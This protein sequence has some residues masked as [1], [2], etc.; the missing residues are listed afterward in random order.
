[1]EGCGWYFLL[2]GVELV[3]SV[4]LVEHLHCV[5]FYV[6]LGHG[7][8]QISAL[9]EILVFVLNYELI[10]QQISEDCL[11]HLFQSLF[12]GLRTHSLSFLKNG[13]G[14]RQSHKQKRRP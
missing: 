11:H 9:V 6:E 7:F 2:L 12:S 5:E 4:V 13:S 1:M 14:T 8:A 3:M 10:L